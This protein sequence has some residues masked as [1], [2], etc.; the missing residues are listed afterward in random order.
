MRKITESVH[1]VHVETWVPRS[2]RVNPNTEKKTTTDRFS[3]PQSSEFLQPARLEMLDKASNGPF[4]K[5]AWERGFNVS[6]GKKMF[7]LHERASQKLSPNQFWRCSVELERQRKYT[8]QPITA[9]RKRTFKTS[10]LCSL[11]RVG[12]RQRHSADI[13]VE[14][15]SRIKEVIQRSW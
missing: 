9:Q 1:F 12:C 8:D 14:T 11:G 15:P 10:V 5:R 13:L 4:S 6:I 2:A 7:P 3:R